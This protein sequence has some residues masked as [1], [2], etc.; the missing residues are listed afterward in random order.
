[1]EA[2]KGPSHVCSNLLVSPSFTTSL[3]Q[4]I[5]QTSGEKKKRKKLKIEQMKKKMKKKIVKKKIVNKLF[6]K[7][8]RVLLLL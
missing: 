2:K 5:N 3:F 4:Q 1:L 7:K 6:W 8:R